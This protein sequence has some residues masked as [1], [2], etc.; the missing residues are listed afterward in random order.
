M[1]TIRTVIRSNPDVN[2]PRPWFDI[3]DTPTGISFGRANIH[4]A[5]LPAVEGKR[6]GLKAEIMAQADLLPPPNQPGEPAAEELICIAITLD[7]ALVVEQPGT[8]GSE[9][10]AHLGFYR[11]ATDTLELLEFVEA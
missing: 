1:I 9:Y 3:R 7:G 8:S 4:G 11:K 10:L 5:K 6:F 2:D